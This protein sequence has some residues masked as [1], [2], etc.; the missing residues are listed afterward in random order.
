MAKPSE[1]D[2]DQL[3]KSQ[4]KLKSD[5]AKLVKE[6]ERLHGA[7]F[8]AASHR[9]YLEKLRAHLL[10]LEA[11]TAAIRAQHEELHQRRQIPHEPHEAEG[12]H[13]PEKSRDTRS[14]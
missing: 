13:R 3:A 10:A 11:H 8:S 7:K 1:L 4:E 14:R 9:H 6:F 5:H 12:L 2:A